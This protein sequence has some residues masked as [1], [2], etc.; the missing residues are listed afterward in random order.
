[1]QISDRGLLDCDTVQSVK[2]IPTVGRTLFFYLH[3]CTRMGQA[4]YLVI[5][6]DCNGTQGKAEGRTGIMNPPLVGK[7]H[8]FFGAYLYDGPDPAPYIF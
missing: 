3:I 7:R 5:H 4:N 1:V 2:R 8:S 6:S